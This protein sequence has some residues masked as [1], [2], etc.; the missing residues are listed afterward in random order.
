M[1]LAP[2]ETQYTKDTE[3]ITNRKGSRVARSGGER[4][5]E[6]DLRC[7][8]TRFNDIA[9]SRDTDAHF[10]AGSSETNHEKSIG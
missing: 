7:A 10:D 8:A 5:I 2:P 4:A 6:V 9:N 1:L 3:H